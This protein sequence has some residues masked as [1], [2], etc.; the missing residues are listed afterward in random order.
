[1]FNNIHIKDNLISGNIIDK[2]IIIKSYLSHSRKAN[3]KVPRPEA[4]IPDAATGT[5]MLRLQCFLPEASFRSP[6]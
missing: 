4:L 6:F 5:A 2:L 1:M 3:F